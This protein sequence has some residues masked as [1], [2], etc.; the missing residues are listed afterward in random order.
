MAAPNFH[1]TEQIGKFTERQAFAL[2][3]NFCSFC[4][5]RSACL[6]MSDCTCLQSQQS[7]NGDSLPSRQSLPSQCFRNFASACLEPRSMWQRWRSPCEFFWGIHQQQFRLPWCRRGLA[8]L[9]KKPKS[10]MT[11]AHFA[12]SSAFLPNNFQHLFPWVRFSEVLH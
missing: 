2:D 9:Q 6:K 10:I 11:L 5:Q 4:A 1:H 8:A 7:K 12:K 3:T